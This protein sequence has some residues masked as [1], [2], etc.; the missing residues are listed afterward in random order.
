MSRVASSRL[1]DRSASRDEGQKNARGDA[2]AFDVFTAAATATRARS[3]GKACDWTEVNASFI[4]ANTEGYS[5]R[6]T[7]SLAYSNTMLVYG[8]TTLALRQTTVTRD[9]SALEREGVD[10]CITAASRARCTRCAPRAPPPA[11]RVEALIYRWTI[12]PSPRPQTLARAMLPSSVAAVAQLLLVVVYPGYLTFKTL[13]HDRKKPDAQRGWCIY[14]AVAS[15]W[16]ALLPAFDY[17]FDARVALYRE[18]KVRTARSH[19]SLVSTL[20]V[21]VLFVA[22]AVGVFRLPVA[23]AVAGRA[24]RLRPVSRAVS[25]RA[26]IRR[27]RRAGDDV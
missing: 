11:L 3:R 23:P 15:A 19:V 6:T 21:L 12:H 25:H 5:T 22:R 27:G 9:T 18:C 14:W 7:R 24:L 17:V 1:V 10:V 13:E 26:R 20:T 16:L 4:R 8:A 2:E